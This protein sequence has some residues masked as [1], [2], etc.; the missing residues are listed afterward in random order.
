MDAVFLLKLTDSAGT[1]F[2]GPGVAELF[3]LIDET[4]SVRHAS[5]KMGL[6]YSKAW[7]MI[8]GTEKATGKAAVTRIQGGKGGGRAELTADGKKLL[9]AFSHLEKEMEAHLASVKEAMIGT[10]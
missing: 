6:S 4:G 7:K 9:E 10:L 5:E 1:P 8:R 2:F 3:T